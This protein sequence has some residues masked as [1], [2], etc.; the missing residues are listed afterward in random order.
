[1][2]PIVFIALKTCLDTY[3]IY[4]NGCPHPCEHDALLWLSC[5]SSPLR[6]D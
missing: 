1:M 2:Q 6:Y 5:S 3:A 4:G